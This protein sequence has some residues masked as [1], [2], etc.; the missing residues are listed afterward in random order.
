MQV[1]AAGIVAGSEHGGLALNPVAGERAGAD[2]DGQV[3][4]LTLAAA[5]S[6]TLAWTALMIWMVVRTAQWALN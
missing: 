3:A 2:I 6:L 5:G 1:K 4:R